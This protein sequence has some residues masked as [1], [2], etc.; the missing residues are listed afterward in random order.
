MA[1]KRLLLAAV[2]F[3]AFPAGAAKAEVNVNI[4]I[5]SPLPH[6]VIASPP[7][8]VVYPGTYVY[9]AT[10]VD[11]DLVFYHD[12]WYRFYGG[13]WYIS[14]GYSGPW[15]IV[16]APLAVR[17]LPQNFRAVPPGHQRL[18]YGQVKD[19][20]KTWEK[21]RHWD[22]PEKGHDRDHDEREHGHGKKHKKNKGHGDGGGKRKHDN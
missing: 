4:N 21:E 6:V 20:W 3:A 17:H 10:D 11:M 1:L 14:A 2:L 16:D 22:H 12:H 7:L 19:N 15:K 9:V 13:G 5:G 18:P 8:L